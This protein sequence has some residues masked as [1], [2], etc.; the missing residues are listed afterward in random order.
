MS[1]ATTT[2]APAGSAHSQR[3]TSNAAVR[4]EPHDSSYRPDVDGL[5]ALAVMLV[6][7]FHAGFGFPGGYIGVDV[8]F[9][10][11]GFL[12]CRLIIRAQ[13]EGTFSL[14]AFWGRRIRRIIPAATFMALVTL[15]AGLFL[16][17]PGDLRELAESTIA[18]Q[19]MASNFYFLHRTDYFDGPADLKP[20]LHTWSLAVEEQFYLAF[21]F[22]ML[23][24]QRFPARRKLMI[25]AA[26]AL[27][28]LVL[29]EVWLNHR[30]AAAFY[31]LPTR[32]WEL[33]VGVILAFVPA[34]RITKTWKLELLGMAGL[35]AILVAATC[36]GNGTRFPGVAAL[37]PCLGTAALIYSNSS[38]LR[39][40][41]R[42][43]SWRPVVAVGLA[44][45]SLYLWHWPILAYLRYCVGENLSVTLRVFALALSL[46]LSGLS[47]KY[48]ETPFR[49][50]LRG[51]TLRMM[52]GAAIC[53]TAVLAG[54]SFWIYRQQGLP[55][56]LP[57]QLRAMATPIP[58]LAEYSSNVYHIALRKLPVLGQKRDKHH[59]PDFL[60]WGDSHAVALGR[61]FS[62][63]AAEYE[64]SG[65]MAAQA[66][67]IPISGVWRRD[68]PENRAWNDAVLTF[69]RDN[70][71]RDVILVGRWESC[72]DREVGDRTD[73]LMTDGK[74]T[75]IDLDA[76][77]EMVTAG[78]SR[79]VEQLEQMGARVW[80]VKQVPIQPFHPQ[81][82]LV[83]CRYFGLDLPAA[84][85]L[86]DHHAAQLHADQLMAAIKR[87]HPEVHILDPQDFC[88]D[89]TGHSRFHD[90]DI[91]FYRDQDHLS[92]EG[93]EQLLR[94][95]IVPV[96]SEISHD[97]G[98]DAARSQTMS[99]GAESS[100]QV[101]TGGSR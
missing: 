84:A 4:N 38:H 62:S 79:T 14:A 81:R 34:P 85:S 48:V 22:V 24:L 90:G 71:I 74:S 99:T 30:A 93:S 61:L 23:A 43:L 3:A 41:G 66:G 68:R 2:I 56:R 78:L 100:R 63:V 42:A 46:V 51:A 57:E 25:F 1:A 5:R 19:F 27:T 91:V 36:Y 29:S 94:P 67:S 8:F 13:N 10:I 59:R 69:I 88:F 65:V 64:L 101:V 33:L 58:P 83:R 50:G 6:L 92:P 76:I 98:M 12:I 7:L 70:R 26:I 11:S 49:R 9:V 35:A 28:S 53:S 96:L 55:Q 31:L 52:I 72:V 15:V 45:Y 60:V 44:S 21:P 16:L 32:M 54:V 87:R 39:R 89:A 75:T 20:L 97:R 80:I 18:Q 37:L 95:M 47:L 77:R 40:I 82:T 86:D 73:V 17:L